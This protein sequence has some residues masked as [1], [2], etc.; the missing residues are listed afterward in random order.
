M[1]RYNQTKDV[2]FLREMYG[3]IE[4][5]HTFWYEHRDT[6]GVGLCSWTQ[7]ME[8]GMDDGV[9]FMQG[10]KTIIL[11]RVD[12]EWGK[13]VLGGLAA[14]TDEAFEGAQGIHGHH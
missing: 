3:E 13:G 6:Q 7:G 12:D 9:R 5:F 14:P 10:T 8:S 2:S 1:L 4:R 11:P